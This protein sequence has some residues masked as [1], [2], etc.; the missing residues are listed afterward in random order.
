MRLPSGAVCPA[1]N[2]ATGFFMCFFT[3][4]AAASSERAADLALHQ[5]R[6]R[7]RRIPLEQLQHVDEVHAL[8]GI[9]ADAP[10]TSTAPVPAW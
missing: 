1:M 8:D 6:A 4:S 9:A 2:A 3:Y 7:A 10:R 5:H